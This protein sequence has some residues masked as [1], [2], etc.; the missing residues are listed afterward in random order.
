[1]KLIKLNKQPG[2]EEKLVEACLRND[3]VAQ[4]ELYDKYKTAMYTTALRITGNSDSAHDALQEAFIAV[5]ENMGSF[6][7]ASTLGAWIKTIVIRKALSIIKLEINYESLDKAE[8]MECT[9]WDGDFTAHDLEKA[10][11]SLPDGA[12]AVFLLVEV[13]GYKHL[14]VAEMLNISEG[15]SKS[16]LNYS[17][18]LLQRKLAQY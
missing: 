5:F 2:L 1:M 8:K 13:E 12:R 6:K 3:R 17:K 4:K 7:F 16:Q 9:S 10:I 14:E 11:E 18:K 15:T